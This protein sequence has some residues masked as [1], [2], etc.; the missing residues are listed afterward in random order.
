MWGV[1]FCGSRKP[2][3]DK[4]SSRKVAKMWFYPNPGRSLLDGLSGGASAELMEQIS[5]RSEDLHWK[6]YFTES[7][8]TGASRRGVFPDLDQNIKSVRSWEKLSQPSQGGYLVGRNN[9]ETIWRP[10]PWLTFWWKLRAGRWRHFHKSSMTSRKTTRAAV[11]A[12][13]EKWR[14]GRRR[15]RRRRSSWEAEEDDNHPQVMTT[16]L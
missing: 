1:I 11:S 14:H 9:F 13:L 15:E 4:M 10:S 6:W 5:R 3:D 8:K 16:W 2:E 12:F 7:W